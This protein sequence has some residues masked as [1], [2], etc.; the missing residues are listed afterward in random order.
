MKALRHGQ[1]TR[2]LCIA[3]A[4][5]AATRDVA[6]HG[7]H[8]FFGRRFT[9][10]KRHDRNTW[11]LLAQEDAMGVLCPDIHLSAIWRRGRSN[12]VWFSLC[13]R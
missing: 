13:F 7:L 4:S 6:T 9:L 11:I 2:L 3:A 8:W 1:Y 10:K 12:S 5:P